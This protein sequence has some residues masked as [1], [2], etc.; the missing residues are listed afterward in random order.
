[1][2]YGDQTHEIHEVVWQS[3]SLLV[4]RNAYTQTC[5]SAHGTFLL[6]LTGRETMGDTFAIERAAILYRIGW[7]TLKGFH[8]KV[9]RY[10]FL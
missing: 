6:D 9:A 4:S 2:G 3:I 1:M 10:V 5:S 8:S 7:M